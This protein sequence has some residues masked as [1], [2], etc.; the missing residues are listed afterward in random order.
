VTRVASFHGSLY[1]KY[2][3]KYNHKLLLYAEN[4]QASL[5]KITRENDDKLK[6]PYLRLSIMEDCGV[7]LCRKIE[8]ANDM[9]WN[10]EAGKTCEALKENKSK[11]NI[12]DRDIPILLDK[13]GCFSTYQISS[14]DVP[15]FD[16]YRLAYEK[17]FKI[18]LVLENM[19][20]RAGVMTLILVR[21]KEGMSLQTDPSTVAVADFASGELRLAVQVPLSTILQPVFILVLLLRYLLGKSLR[22]SSQPASKELLRSLNSNFLQLADSR[23]NV[24]DQKHSILKYPELLEDLKEFNTINLTASLRI[25]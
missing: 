23:Q 24:M 19:G 8:I 20:R 15:K 1:G 10:R 5:A 14:Q 25:V 16:N 21:D 4:V 12:E 22:A 3:L 7:V 13:V 17:G 18:Q 11:G 6:A 9:G 2:Y